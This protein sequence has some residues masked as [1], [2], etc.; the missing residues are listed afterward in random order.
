MGAGWESQQLLQPISG[1]RPCGENLEDTELP[2]FD[3]FQLF[4]QPLPLDAPVVKDDRGGCLRRGFR[5]RS[6][7]PNGWRF[8]T[9]RP[10]R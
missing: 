8:A 3:A 9:R 5:S 7:R 4:G 1:E 2:S 10:R 6:I